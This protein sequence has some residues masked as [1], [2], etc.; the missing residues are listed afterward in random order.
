[1]SVVTVCADVIQLRIFAGTIVN[2]INVPSTTVSFNVMGFFSYIVAAAAFKRSSL[3]DSTDR[4]D[5]RAVTPPSF[6]NCNLENKL[7]FSRNLD[8]ENMSISWINFVQQ[9]Q[10]SGTKRKIFYVESF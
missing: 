6:R 2:G 3:M 10:K 9:C 8:T 7:I 4:Y 5:V 1:M